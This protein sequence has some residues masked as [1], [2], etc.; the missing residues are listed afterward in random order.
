MSQSNFTARCAAPTSRLGL[1]AWAFGRTGWGAQDD[2]DS[3]AAILRAI[4]LGVSW[5]DTAA[6]YGDGH[7]ENLV[8]ATLAQ[9]SEADRPLVY[10]KGGLRVDR[11]SGVT[12]RDLSPGSLREQ[13]QESLRRLR[14]ERIDLY[15]LHWPVDDHRVVEQACACLREL[16]AEG[17][18]HR[19][20]VSNFDLPL[21]KRCTEHYPIDVVQVPLSLLSRAGG[22]D[23][24]PWSTE[25]G[26]RALTYSPLES[27][28]LSGHFSKQRLQALPRSDWRR[29]RVQFR[30]PRLDR[31][32]ELLDRLEP[33]AASCDIS[34][35]QLAIAWTLTWPGVAGAIVG[36]RSAAQVDGWAGASEV[37][38]DAFTV[39]QIDSAL[40]ATGAGQGPTHPNRRA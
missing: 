29:E 17:K 20:G 25:H 36:A 11:V 23:L 4:E 30:Q 12:V 37:R 2:R 27:G 16:Q 5:I 21:L 18:I 33:I 15:Q 8:G 35:A 14:V 38:L 39:D 9:C 22:G 28:L 10:T 26:V 7:S 6:V 31:T 1:G 32:L 40:I 13:C 24:L 34:L 19:I 3:R